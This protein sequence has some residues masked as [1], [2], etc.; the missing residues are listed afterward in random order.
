MSITVGALPSTSAVNL[1][2]GVKQKDFERA[3]LNV[4]IQPMPNGA[5]ALAAVVG[6]SIN[7]ALAN[8]LSLAQAY[9]R[10][11]PVR[12]IASSGSENPESANGVQLLVAPDSRIASAHDLVGKVVGVTSVHD[13][14]TVAISSWLERNGVDRS[15]VSY[16]ELPP[17]AMYNALK[18]G[19]VAAIALFDPFLSAAKKQGARVLAQPYDGIAPRFTVTAWFGVE[20]WIAANREAALR[21]AS[22]LD[23]LAPYTNTHYEELV[24]LVSSYTKVPED[25]LRTMSHP[26]VLSLKAAPIQPA[27]DAALKYH[28]LDRAVD[29]RNIVLP[30]AV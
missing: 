8:V 4:S 2:Y 25:M 6:G 16:I 7:I 28:E 1:Y 24:P 21:F 29:A 13:L 23:R 22:V 19:R 12:V 17:S 27:L 3:G 20:P 9:L 30:G 26:T 10:G 14:L 5:A 18:M 15:T 11:I